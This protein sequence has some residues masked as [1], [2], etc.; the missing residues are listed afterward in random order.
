[1]LGALSR[2]A[3][4]VAA[5]FAFG[6]VM[7][8]LPDWNPSWDV[9][10]NMSAPWVVGPLLV[11]RSQKSL[12]WAIVSATVAAVV[13]IA[14]FYSNVFPPLDAAY[15]RLPAASGPA[16]LAQGAY[17]IWFDAHRQWFMAAA[18]TGPVAGAVGY[19]WRVSSARSFAALAAAPLLFEPLLE[20]FGPW[21]FGSTEQWLA[22]F[23]VG[24]LILG[25]GL[26]VSSRGVRDDVNLPDKRIDA[27]TAD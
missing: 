17:S 19:W 10:A 22:E 3:L 15:L 13:G 8:R 18:L 25:A 5:M 14:G 24:L 4:G 6:F 23:C 16:T 20:V 9:A 26:A 1:M 2:F 21:G 27:P 7:G 11:G 12:V